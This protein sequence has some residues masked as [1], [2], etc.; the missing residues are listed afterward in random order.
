MQQSDYNAL[1]V[2]IFIFLRT[3]LDLFNHNF[4]SYITCA[5]INNKIQTKIW[6]KLL[7]IQSLTQ[8]SFLTQLL[9]HPL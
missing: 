7:H 9:L 8:E 5:H 1:L 3:I 4:L 6:V 2:T